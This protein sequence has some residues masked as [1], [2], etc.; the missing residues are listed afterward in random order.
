M[1]KIDSLSLATAL[2][3]A[4]SLHESN[5]NLISGQIGLIKRGIAQG[6]IKV[7]ILAGMEI[8]EMFVHEQLAMAED[9]NKKALEAQE[10]VRGAE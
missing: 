8:L 10:A 6:D 2:A 1:I 5:L 4:E 7:D 3:N 9:A